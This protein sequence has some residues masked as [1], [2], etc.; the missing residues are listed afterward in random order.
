MEV[1]RRR[2]S[3]STVWNIA[4]LVDSRGP[5]QAEGIASADF[6]CSNWTTI[7]AFE[8]ANSGKNT[9][10]ASVSMTLA[11]GKLML[12]Y[13]T[14]NETNSVRRDLVSY[15]HNLFCHEL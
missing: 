2:R 12:E 11:N 13:A 4:Q 14:R 5:T 9:A 15:P 10:K 1:N 6:A 3:K 8:T 7:I